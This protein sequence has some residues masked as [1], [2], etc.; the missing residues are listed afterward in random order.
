MPQNLQPGA[1]FNM[2]SN[3]MQPGNGLNR[4]YCAMDDFIYTDG[5]RRPGAPS[6]KFRKRDQVGCDIVQPNAIGLNDFYESSPVLMI[7][8]ASVQQR[9]CIPGNRGERC[10]ELV[11]DIGHKVAF[12]PF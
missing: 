4:V 3:L 8:E 9:L 1:V 7:L 6:L 2:Q 5:G 10:S 11:R 12:G